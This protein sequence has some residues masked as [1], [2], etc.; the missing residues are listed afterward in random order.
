MDS[1]GAYWRKQ[2]LSQK[3]PKSMNNGVLGNVSFFKT[4][5]QILSTSNFHSISTLISEAF[6]PILISSAILLTTSQPPP[7]IFPSESGIPQRKRRIKLLY[8]F[9]YHKMPLRNDW[10]PNDW[11]DSTET[12][13]PM[14]PL[15]QLIQPLPV[16]KR[17]VDNSKS[18][19]IEH[20]PSSVL[21]D[22]STSF[23]AIMCVFL[24]HS[25]RVFFSVQRDRL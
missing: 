6:F 19:A 23:L 7:F 3:Q 21:Q 22:C 1:K 18:P 11:T 5:N 8:N 9:V 24:W 14:I 25:S 16:R 4:Q 12:T 13:E 15:P 17:R 2:T 20:L 10:L